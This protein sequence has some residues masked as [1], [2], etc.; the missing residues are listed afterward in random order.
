VLEL[1]LLVAELTTFI[2]LMRLLLRLQRRQLLAI[3][4]QINPIR[5]ALEVLELTLLVAEL[6]T[7]IELMRLL[8]RLQRRQLLAITSQ[9]NPIDTLVCFSFKVNFKT[10]SENA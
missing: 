4:S 5:V 3:T 6:T 9:I 2:E 7:F 8:L 1:T 10:I